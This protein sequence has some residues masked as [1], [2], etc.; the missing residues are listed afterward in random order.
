MTAAYKKGTVQSADFLFDAQ[1]GALLVE[2]AGIPAEVNQVKSYV[3]INQTGAG[4]VN[5]GQSAGQSMVVRSIGISVD[6]GTSY[7]FATNA[8]AVSAGATQV[9]G[10]YTIP[11]GGTWLN[12]DLSFIRSAAG[13]YLLLVV[14]A[15]GVHG[16]ATVSHD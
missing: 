13:Q 7:Y 3:A 9:A 6:A 16:G 2:Q 11:I 10:P 15:G 8:T 5:L 12:P 1:T 4:V 14:T